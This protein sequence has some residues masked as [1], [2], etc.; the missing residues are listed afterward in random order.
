[1]NDGLN[2]V[3]GLEIDWEKNDQFFLSRVEADPEIVTVTISAT[4]KVEGYSCPDFW[5]SHQAVFPYLPGSETDVNQFDT[6]HFFERLGY[7]Q[8]HLWH[9]AKY[10]F[11]KIL[12]RDRQVFIAAKCI[13]NNGPDRYIYRSHKIEVPAMRGEMLVNSLSQREKARVEDREYWKNYCKNA[14][15]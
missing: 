10:R 3:S 7:A 5:L 12:G 14:D 2:F 9:T 8:F 13:S 11:L 1:M 6:A 15:Y 4:S